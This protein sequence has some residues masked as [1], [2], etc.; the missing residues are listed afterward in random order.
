MIPPVF[1][2]IL[3]ILFHL[4]S[5]FFAATLVTAVAT[6]SVPFLFDAWH[7]DFGRRW[8]GWAA[9]LASSRSTT[10][11]RSCGNGRIARYEDERTLLAPVTALFENNL[12]VWIFAT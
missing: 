12:S 5:S 1:L 7:K 9:I 2:F 4:S 8:M 11:M 10:E 3:T 6:T